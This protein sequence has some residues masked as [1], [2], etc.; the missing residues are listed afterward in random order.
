MVRLSVHA[1]AAFTPQEILLVHIIRGRDDP[2]A[3]M[4]P[5]GL[6]EWK[7]PVTPSGIEPA[8]FRFVE[9]CLNQMLHRVPQKLNVWDQIQVKD[10]N[11]GNLFVVYVNWFSDEWS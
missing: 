3:I 9:Q 5:E 2:R 4:R 8:T 1:P 7:I 11:P 10:H 6:C